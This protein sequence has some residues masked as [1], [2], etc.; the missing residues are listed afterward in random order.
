MQL[1]CMSN[2]ATLTWMGHGFGLCR[3]QLLMQE[4]WNDTYLPITEPNNAEVRA[5]VSGLPAEE[6]A[7]ITNEEAMNR[8]NERLRDPHARTIPIT[9][10]LVALINVSLSNLTQDQRQV[11]TLLMAHRNRVLADYRL[12]EL[13]EVYLETFLVIDGGYLDNHEG[14]WVED[15]EDGTEGFLEA[16]DDTF[17]VYDEEKEKEERKEKE[18]LEEKSFVVAEEIK[19]RQKAYLAL[20][21]IDGFEK[22][23]VRQAVKK[24]AWARNCQLTVSGYSSVE[25]ATGKRPPDLLDAETS[26]PEQLSV[27]PAEEDRTTL[28]LQRIAMRAHQEARQSIELRKDQ[29]RRAMPSD[30]PYKKGDRVFVWHKDESKK[31]SE[32]I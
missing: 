12:N 24:V 2:V 19:F 31:K 15:E 20:V 30:G 27:D 5:F 26:T 29:A 14:Y 17:W 9:A 16:D 13:R 25:T 8:A 18:L 1:R 6:Q 4:A 11:L 32:G 28:D 21:I 22:V 10:N 23:T 7:D 3:A